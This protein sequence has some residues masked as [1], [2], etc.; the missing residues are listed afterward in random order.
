[1]F[2]AL[3]EDY[4][5]LPEPYNNLAVLSRSAANTKA[6]ERRSKPP[7][8]PRPTGR[9]PH[10]NLGDIYAR[11]AA[12]E[13]AQ[14]AKLDKGNK[15][16]PAKLALVRDLLASCR[17]RETEVVAVCSRHLV[18]NQRGV[19]SMLRRPFLIAAAVLATRLRRCPRS[20]PIPQVEFD[21][22]AGKIKVELFPDAAPKTV[23]N[24]LD[25]V[26]AKH[27]DGTQFHRVIPG[28]MI[29][30]GGFTPDFKQKPTKPPIPIESEQ[31]SKAGHDE[32]AGHARHGAHRRS[33]LR[34][35]RSSSST[36]TTTSS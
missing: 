15:T 29:Q 24:F 33:Q 31:S 32:R 6:R 3:I 28:F 23:A 9:S 25:Y 34:H 7:S 14:A 11:L 22:T 36:S 17:A 16:A 4:P 12:V 27:Y 8:A 5:E 2:R 19:A 20:P 10:E 30:G 1:M 21:T 18:S 26:K 35:R 13:Y